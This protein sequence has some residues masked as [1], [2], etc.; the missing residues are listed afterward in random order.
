MILKDALRGIAR[1]QREALLSMDNGVERESLK[2][3]AMNSPFAMI[4]S[5][6]RRCG[7]S[8]LLK[9]ISRKLDTFYYFNFEDPRLA[10][11]EVEDFQKLNEVFEEEFGKCDYYLL[12]EIQNVKGWE[13][14]VRSMLDRRGRFVITGSNASLLSREL[15][16]RLT[17]RHIRYEL[18]PFSFK[19]F[20]SFNKFR[21][22]ESSFSDYLNRGGFPDYLRFTRPDVLQ[23]LLNDVIARDIIVRRGIRNVQVVRELAI[24]LITNIGKEFSYNALKKLFMLGSVNSAISFVSSFEESYLFFTVPRFDYSFKSQIV[25]PK[26]IYCIDNGLAVVNSASFSG[27]RGR[28]LENAVFLE[29]RRRHK[30]IFYF[31]GNGECDFLVKEAG[32]IVEAVQVCWELNSDNTKH[33]LEGLHEAAMKSGVKRGL[34]LTFSQEDKLDY[35]GI[36]VA[37][38]PVWKWMAA[39]VIGENSEKTWKR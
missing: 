33:E 32:K 27:D 14:F 20:L 25:S 7:K 31:R 15:G 37:V 34:V 24:Y 35:E 28:L 19:E 26:K 16:T 5:G 1:S 4:I 29:L 13:L 10:A 18:F 22:D 23:E 17:G 8:T 9:Q 38:L 6:I 36:H 30:E 11:F 39:L 21:P 2:K 12:D 3:I